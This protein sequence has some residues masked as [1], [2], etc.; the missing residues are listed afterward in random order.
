MANIHTVSDE[1]FPELSRDTELTISRVDSG[2]LVY[3]ISG[4]IHLIIKD[5]EQMISSMSTMEDVKL[6]FSPILKS[7][8]PSTHMNIILKN[9]KE[10][11]R[12]YEYFFMV[13]SE[14][15][16]ETLLVLKDLKRLILHLFDNRNRRSFHIQLDDRE[17]ESIET[18][19][20]EIS[21]LL[22]KSTR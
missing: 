5:T 13:E 10:L 15:D 22:T 19:S 8:F 12:R 21:D 4:E 7:E 1:I 9:K 3:Y 20:E 2:C 16:S 18:V 6:R 17:S 14:T 11:S